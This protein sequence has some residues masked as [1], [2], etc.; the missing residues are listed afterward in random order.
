M[1]V[2]T[3]KWHVRAACA[4][5][6]GAWWWPETKQQGNAG[7]AVCATCP[8]LA[9][10]LDDA[11][12][13]REDEGIW[14]GAG[15]NLRRGFIRLR[16][17][18]PHDDP[19]PVAGCGCGWCRGVKRHVE[20]LRVGSQVTDRP[21][22]MNRN[23][24]SA[25]HGVRATQSKGCRCDP[26]NWSATKLGQALTRVGLDT[27]EHWDVWADVGEPYVVARM[28]ADDAARALI[29][30]AV[31]PLLAAMGVA[32]GWS[33]PLMVGGG[34]MPKTQARELAELEPD[35]QAVTVGERC[36]IR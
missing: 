17:A 24:R 33:A 31:R 9:N 23:G 35:D 25:R 5:L 21:S 6:P 18:R 4:G 28:P 34:P 14:G 20:T 7:K 19:A 3:P 11:V 13:R 32:E 1:L 30:A 16:L 8:V 12:G 26:C 27:A 10:C 29:E 36:C 22:V 15:E 2:E